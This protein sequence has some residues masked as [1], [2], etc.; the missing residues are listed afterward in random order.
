MNTLPLRHVALAV[1][2]A[3]TV[4]GCTT[5]DDGYGYNYGRNYYA[6][7]PWAYTYGTPYSYFGWYDN[8]YYP[9]VGVYLYDGS[10]LRYRWDQS[11]QRY[12]ESRRGRDYRGQ[13]N[14]SGYRNRDG[15]WQNRERDGN[16]RRVGRRR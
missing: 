2:A 3:A 15:N 12:W 11:Q 13:E 14:W 4:A 16:E 9:G 1:C 5:Y 7:R 10:G 8:F 6:S